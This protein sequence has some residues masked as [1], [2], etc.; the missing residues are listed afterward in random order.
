MKNQAS[1]KSILKKFN[2]LDPNNEILMSLM[3]E[4]RAEMMAS[5]FSA[6]ES[7]TSI[8]AESMI[9]FLTDTWFLN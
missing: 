2:D 1:T 9:L 3:K 6:S 8:R 5:K 4:I 7:V